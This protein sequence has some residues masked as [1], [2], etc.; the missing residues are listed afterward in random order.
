MK[1]AQKTAAEDGWRGRGQ[2]SVRRWAEDGGRWSIEDGRWQFRNGTERKAE[3][4]KR[5]SRAGE[6][7]VISQYEEL[8]L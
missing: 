2:K 8:P 3:N 4:R 5:E 7:V 1:E 6:K